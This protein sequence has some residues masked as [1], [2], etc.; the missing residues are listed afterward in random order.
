MLKLML[1]LKDKKRK[2]K[3]AQMAVSAPEIAAK[4]N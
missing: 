1:I 3:R 2:A 4:E